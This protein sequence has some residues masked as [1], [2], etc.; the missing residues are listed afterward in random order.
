MS[1]FTEKE[2]EYLK[3]Q[4]IGRLATV[5]ADGEPHVVPT[6]FRYN[7]ELDAIDVVGSSIGTSKKFR[8][9]AR[10]GKAAI[11]IDDVPEPRKQRGIEVRGRAEA[12]TEG[13]EGIMPGVDSHF[14][15]ITPT[16]VASWGIDSDPFT[17]IG[18]AVK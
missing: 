13:G 4:R 7:A 5:S 1:V 2:I 3:S 15:R 11:V 12:L 6:R 14:I 8:D 16:R 10:T 18:R 17:P 9:V